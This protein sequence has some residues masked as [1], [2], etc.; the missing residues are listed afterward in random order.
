MSYESLLVNTCDI[1]RFTA[2]AQDEYGNPAKAWAV[3]HDDEPCRWSTPKN[4]E[5]KVGAE[6]VIADL[7]LF[8][9]DVDITEQD[10]VVLDSLTY[11]VLSVA[12]RQDAI[13]NH[14]VEC[15][16]RVIQ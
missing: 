16:L 15:M 4:R 8:L 2:G 12:D 1:S 10:R 3:L 11:E 6:V 5:V 14:H 13:G 7:Q 9:G